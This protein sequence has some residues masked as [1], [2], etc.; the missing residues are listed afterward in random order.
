MEYNQHKNFRRTDGRT[1]ET[2][3]KYKVFCVLMA[4][5]L[6]LSACGGKKPAT[7]DPAPSAPSAPSEP[8]QSGKLEPSKE[9]GFFHVDNIEDLFEA[10]R[11]GAGIIL[12]A[13]EYNLS[14][15]LEDENLDIHKFN[16]EHEYL[17]IED[18]S[19]GHQLVITGCDALYIEGAGSGGNGTHIVVEPRYAAVLTY[20]NCH[21]AQLLNMKMGHTET[22]SCSGNVVDFINVDSAQLIG[23]DLYGCGVYG[24][25]ARYCTGKFDITGSTIRECEY[26]PFDLT[27][28]NAEFTFDTCQLVDSRGGGSMYGCESSTFLFKN[29]RFG[30]KESNRWYFDEDIKQENCD[31]MEPTEYPDY[32]YEG[33]G[34]IWYDPPEYH[35]EHIARVMFERTMVENTNWQAL[36]LVDNSTKDVVWLPTYDADGDFVNITA[37]FSESEGDILSWDETTHF[38]WHFLDPEN[39]VMECDGYNI[40]M[41]MWADTVCEAGT[42]WMAL[43]TEEN[44]IWLFQ[45]DD[46]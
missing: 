1:E 27:N 10:I 44:T 18:I 39:V 33:D 22:G 12:A 40:Y 32:G 14:G 36:I 6:V 26:G 8:E 20:E 31:W 16:S 41:S 43:A 5:L 11:P 37:S 15:F 29:C 17:R 24:I 46:L 19:D 13:G 21:L 38:S 9:D 28:C 3:K 25:G 4:L 45:T 35:S 34:P 23:M 42:N 30:Q 2:M 7:D